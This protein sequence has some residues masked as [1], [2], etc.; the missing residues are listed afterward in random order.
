M[1]YTQNIACIKCLGIYFW[2]PHLPGVYWRPVL[3]IQGRFLILHVQSIPTWIS[4]Y[5]IMGKL[6]G[7]EFSQKASLQSFCGFIFKDKHTAHI[8]SLISFH[9]MGLISMDWQVTDKTLKI[10]PLENFPLYGTHM[11]VPFTCAGYTTHKFFANQP[12]TCSWLLWACFSY[13]DDLQHD[14]SFVRLFALGWAHQIGRQKISQAQD[15]EAVAAGSH[16]MCECHMDIVQPHPPPCLIDPVWGP[17][18]P[19]W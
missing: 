11:Y 15:R 2:C 8:C 13:L 6:R 5:H 16:Y 9:F 12:E 10:G 17:V 7:V 4:T 19:L 1:H 3:F 14:C 18:A